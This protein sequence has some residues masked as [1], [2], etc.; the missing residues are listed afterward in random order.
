MSKEKDVKITFNPLPFT[1]IKLQLE[2]N[3]C[4]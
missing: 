3:N 4:K 1:R 2:Q